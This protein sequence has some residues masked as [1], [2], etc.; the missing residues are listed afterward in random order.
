MFCNKCGADNNIQSKF[1]KNCGEQF[2]IGE[3]IKPVV[4]E[5]AAPAPVEKVKAA[6]TKKRW[7]AAVSMIISIITVFM[8]FSNIATAEIEV[9]KKITGGVYNNYYEIEEEFDA[10]IAISI[11]MIIGNADMFKSDLIEEFVGEDNEGLE[12][13]NE[14]LDILKIACMVVLG[15]ILV[16]FTLSSFT[17]VTGGRTAVGFSMLFNITSFIISLCLTAGMVVADS[18]LTVDG[19]SLNFAPAPVIAVAFSFINIVYVIIMRKQIR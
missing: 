15:I 2:Y 1:C 18:M 17:L 14:T 12:T 5:V 4:S 10:D 19:L 11:P 9:V 6:P 3:E 7:I 8:M 13:L 16:L